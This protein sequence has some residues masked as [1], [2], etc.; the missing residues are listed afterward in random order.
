MR[1]LHFG[2][3]SLV[4]YRFRGWPSW[5][6]TWTSYWSYTSEESFT[7][8]ENIFVKLLGCPSIEPDLL[9]CRISFGQQELVMKQ[10]Y[11]YLMDSTS[12]K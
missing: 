4:G 3:K 7:S 8:I 12:Y 2:L 9:T 6:R 1:K 10:N 5:D 11:L